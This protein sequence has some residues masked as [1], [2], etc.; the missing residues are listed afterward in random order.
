MP[1]KISLEACVTTTFAY[2]KEHMHPDR[3]GPE[4]NE[5]LAELATLRRKAA[6]LD[7]LEAHTVWSMLWN[8]RSPLEPGL[9]LYDKGSLLSAAE[10]AKEAGHG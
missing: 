9:S 10:G 3:V 8:K 7:W 4:T 5:L 1:H 6:A 2:T